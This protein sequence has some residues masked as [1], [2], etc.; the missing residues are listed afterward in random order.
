M[1][2]TAMRSNGRN[3]GIR[4]AHGGTVVPACPISRPVTVV[5]FAE[6]TDSAYQGW[7]LDAEAPL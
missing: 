1:T 3:A 4:P 2:T 5:V 6:S 7:K